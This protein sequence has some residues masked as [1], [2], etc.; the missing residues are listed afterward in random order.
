VDIPRFNLFSK[1]FTGSKN[2]AELSFD[3]GSIGQLNQQTALFWL[4]LKLRGR[5]VDQ[6][7]LRSLGA[8]QHEVP[9]SLS[10]HSSTQFANI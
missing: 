10:H 5:A 4:V 2:K 3:A 7:R 6:A 9:S 1:T 8:E